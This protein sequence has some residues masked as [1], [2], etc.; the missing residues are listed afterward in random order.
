MQTVE[1]RTPTLSPPDPEKL[2]RFV[3][4]ML[5]DIGAVMTGGPLSGDGRGGSFDIGRTGQAHWFE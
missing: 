4:R 3:G 1:S 5:G 2:D